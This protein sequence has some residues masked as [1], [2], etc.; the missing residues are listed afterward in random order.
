MVNLL[1]LNYNNYYNRKFKTGT[2]SDYFALDNTR[3][4]NNVNF[5]PR[6][7]IMTEQVINFTALQDDIKADYLIVYDDDD[8]LISRWFIIE[9][10]WNREH[11]V[12]LTLRRDLLVDFYDDYKNSPFF[13][14]KGL[15]P[16]TDNFI[17]NPESMTFNQILQSRSVLKDGNNTCR[18]VVCYF[19]EGLAGEG[20]VEGEIAGETVEFI[21]S[22]YVQIPTTLD[23]VSLTQPTSGAHFTINTRDTYV[24]KKVPYWIVT[25]PYDE[26]IVKY[27]ENGSW[28]QVYCPPEMNTSVMDFISRKFKGSNALYDMQ[29]LPYCPLSRD[30]WEFTTIKDGNNVDVFAI[31][32]KKN[33][34]KVY[35]QRQLN[36]TNEDWIEGPQGCLIPVIDPEVRF[37]INYSYPYSLSNAEQYKIDS[38]CRF[39]R[40]V[41]PNGSGV[42][43]F[44]A[45]KNGGITQ[46]NVR[47]TLKPFSPTI[48]IVPKFGRLYKSTYSVES[49]GLICQGDFSAPM[50]TDSWEDYQINNKNYLNAFNR[51][52]DN[53]EWNQKI[54]LEHM[55][56]A[57]K[58][59]VASA[60]VSGAGTGY[61]MSGGNPIATGVG[62]LAG[63][64]LS[65]VGLETD[66]MAQ[67]ALNY[68]AL[69]YTK[70]MFRMNMQNVQALPHGL[71][72][73]GS[74]DV[75]TSTQPTIEIYSASDVEINALKKKLTWNGF[76]IGRIGTVAE[77]KANA[78][79]VYTDIDTKYVKGVLVQCDIQD[80]YHIANEISLELNKGVYFV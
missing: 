50:S 29:I 74:L 63:A 77:F 32:S 53:M 68:E 71:A 12:I 52:I 46:F 28:K 64:A 69:D 11:Q 76:S 51:G 21:T 23:Y 49:R 57:G 19:A 80:D 9:S 4:I 40:L 5:N 1:L 58:I 13:C 41:S 25:F 42:F 30:E 73:S 17:Y 15:V 56:A 3:E 67:K 62:F 61:M 33:N 44:N 22:R 34:L 18:W 37:N 20:S 38:E 43:Q 39:I 36:I 72:N 70:D 24:T 35:R 8:N 7:G 55:E 75:V 48:Q 27:Q 79:N 78:D 16:Y 47:M 10:V 54:Q 59:N 31:Q 14:E 66:L 2:I 6:D 60:G 45:A 26:C 65:S